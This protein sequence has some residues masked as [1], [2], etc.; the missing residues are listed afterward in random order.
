MN[1]L[2]TH[3]KTPAER[4]RYSIDYSDWLDTG[5]TCVSTVFTITP[6]GELEV[7]AHE[8]TVDGDQLIFFVNAGEADADYT[9]NV[10]TTTSGGQTTEDEV[11][12]EVR[13]L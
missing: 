1:I 9:I 4:K 6:P 7:D 2:D 13:E 10:K 3:Q 12:F 11:L 8:F 5:E